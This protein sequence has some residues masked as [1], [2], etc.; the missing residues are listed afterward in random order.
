MPANSLPDPSVMFLYLCMTHSDLTKIDFNAVGD[1]VGLKHTAARMR[2]SRLKKQIES[3]IVDGKVNLKAS[4]NAATTTSPAAA[5]PVCTGDSTEDDEDMVSAPA[6]A[7]TTPRKKKGN[8]TARPKAKVEK[9][10][11]KKSTTKGKGTSI[12]REND[13]E[14]YDLVD[15]EMGDAAT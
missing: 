10:S 15:E 7:A 12:K 5:P 2:Y 1:A 6:S 3:G 11:K 8:A 13:D 4:D 9:A 14:G